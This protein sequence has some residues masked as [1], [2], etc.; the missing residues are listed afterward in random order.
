L[1]LHANS[2]RFEERW[3]EKIAWNDFLLMT[4]L[5][6]RSGEDEELTLWRELVRYP[7]K[8]REKQQD[9]ISEVGMPAFFIVFS[10]FA[11]RGFGYFARLVSAI[12]ISSISF[13]Q[14]WK[15]VSMFN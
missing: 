2:G 15:M 4:C 5:W 3:L 12:T 10:L 11:R 6:V 7:L 8:G 13:T 1:G 9:C 14:M